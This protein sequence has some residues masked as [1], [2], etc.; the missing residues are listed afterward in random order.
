MVQVDWTLEH[1]LFP[2]HT[3]SSNKKSNVEKTRPSKSGLVFLSVYVCGTLVLSMKQHSAFTLVEL[4][5]VVA[6]IGL[7]ASVSVYILGN[8]RQKS[9]DAKRVSDIQIIRAGLEQ[10]WLERASY[11]SAPSQIQL[12]TGSGSVLCSNGFVGT[13]EG[14]VYL[15]KVPSGPQTGEYYLYMSDSPTIGYSIQ[16]TMEGE[17]VNG[18][19]GT[20][21]AHSNVIDS[22]ATV[23]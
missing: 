23:K 12:G 18:P 4:M 20:Y 1:T 14:V 6:I 21:Y 3:A 2:V 11:P 19:A 10:H 16:F 5:I 7:L 13:A 15:P 9:R 17:S 8:A 22:E